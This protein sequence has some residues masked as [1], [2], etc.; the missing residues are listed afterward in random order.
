LPTSVLFFP[1][2]LGG[3][4]RYSAQGL[5]ECT[6]TRFGLGQLTNRP[7]GGD[8]RETLARRAE[9]VDHV[10]EFRVP[11]A[12]VLSVHACSPGRAVLV[13]DGHPWEALKKFYVEN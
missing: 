7:L 10:G 5:M 1:A 11:E 12:T 4:R 3:G 6:G 8:S 2:F 13:G 9:G